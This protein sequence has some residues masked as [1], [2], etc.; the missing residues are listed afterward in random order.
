MINKKEWGPWISV[1]IAIAK[2]LRPTLRW[3]KL[4]R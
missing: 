4:L 2:T 1:F 3:A